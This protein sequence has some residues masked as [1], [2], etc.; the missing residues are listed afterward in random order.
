L[1]ERITKITTKEEGK[2]I[3]LETLFTHTNKVTKATI[4]SVIAA[5]AYGTSTVSQKALAEIAAVE[6]Y[7]NPDLASGT[8]LDGI[9]GDKGIAAR[10]GASGSSTW[11]RI[12]AAEG[13]TYTSGTHT[14]TGNSGIIFDLDANITIDAFG[15]GYAKVSSST[16]GLDANIKALGITTVAPI[17]A[18]HS[19]CF[20]EYKA[21]GGRDAEGD[22]LFR[23]RIKEGVNILARGTIS[24]LEQAFIKANNNVLK[25]FNHGLD[26][27]GNI[28]IAIVTQNG[29]DLSAPELN[30]LLTVASEFVSL[31]E[32][33]PNGATA[34]G[35]ILFN[36][37]YFAVDVNFRVSLE[38][39]YNP[40][41]YRIEVQ[42]KMAK[43]LDFRTF[44]PKEDLV[45]WDD[46][47]EIAKNSKGARYVPDQFFFLNSSRNDVSVTTGKL[48]RIRSFAIYDSNGVV[49][50]DFENVLNSVF[51][52]S[53]TD[54]NYQLTVLRSL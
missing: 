47:L 11:I 23:K 54:L 20:N 16:N 37:E 24:A 46:L 22:D 14:F 25:I 31:T 10:F 36:I 30:I 8:Q 18:G 19:R 15:Y 42:T 7:L 45:E 1:A 35:I 41:T 3:F 28:K 4:N 34:Y 40:D 43:Y 29:V 13:T 50:Q 12:E 2:N 33:R 53:Q 26:D 48:P 6:S 9:A 5:I 44:D 38:A 17:P 21:T 52:P 49:I 39:G 27:S 32:I 51:Y